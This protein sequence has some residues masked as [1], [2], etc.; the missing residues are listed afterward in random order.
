MKPCLRPLLPIGV[1]LLVLGIIAAG[2]DGDGEL[3]LEEYFGQLEALKEETDAQTEALGVPEEQES[4]S[5]E[6]QIEAFRESFEG[7]VRIFTDF[8]DALDDIDP[9]AEVEGPHEESVAAGRELVDTFQDFIDGM[10][11][12]EST[13]ELDAVFEEEGPGFEAA[14]DRFD[15][16]CF[17]LEEI[18]DANGIA[19]DL[20]CDDEE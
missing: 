16:A 9:P 18:A 10:A 14:S 17:A 15:N 3:T 12:V 20:E 19:F 4:D 1:S 2:C 8:V 13:S 11:D 6:E 7:S 5:E